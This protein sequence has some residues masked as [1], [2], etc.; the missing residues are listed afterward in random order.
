MLAG[1]ATGVFTSL[2]SAVESCVRIKNEILPDEKNVE[3]Y[4]KSF[5][6]YKRIHDS[7]KDIYREENNIF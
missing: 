7:L 1:V 6:K 4:K 5:K 2:E 3:I